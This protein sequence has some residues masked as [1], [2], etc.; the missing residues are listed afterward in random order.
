[1]LNRDCA[2][3]KHDAPGRCWSCAFQPRV[4]D[5]NQIARNFNLGVNVQEG[6]IHSEERQQMVVGVHPMRRCDLLAPFQTEGLFEGLGVE[7]GDLASVADGAWA[8][9]ERDGDAGALATKNALFF[10][11]VFVPSLA[12]HVA[13]TQNGERRRDFADRFSDALK[14]RL[15]HQPAPLQSFVH[16]L[17]LA[18]NTS[19]PTR[20]TEARDGIR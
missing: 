1:M 9:Y 4:K 19:A 14:K 3:R 11:S 15:V 8:Q 20:T 10:R 18:R 7:S 13:A 16:T 6:T 12:L 5:T 2:H 17:V